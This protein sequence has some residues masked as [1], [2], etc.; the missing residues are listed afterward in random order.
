MSNK[1]FTLEELAEILNVKYTGD[2]SCR[3]SGVSDLKSA[4]KEDV[5]FLS[6]EK[7]T[8]LLKKTSAGIICVNE[9]VD[10]E[11]SKNYLIA[12]D[13]SAIFAKVCEMLI[14]DE[15]RSGFTKIH[16]TACI[17]Q[18]A[19]IGKN[20]EIGPYA[21]I[22]REVVIGDGTIIYSHV[23]V[24]PKSVLGSDCIIY[25]NTVIREQCELGNRVLLQP[26]CVIGSCGY[27]YSSCKKTGVHTKIKQLG[28]V[29]LEDDVEIGSS[30]T[31]DRGRFSHTIIRKGTKI[32]NQCMIGHNCDV[33]MNN[34]IVSMSGLSGSV[35]TGRNVI[36]AAQCGL[37]GHIEIADGVTLAAR[38]T[39]TKS[40]KKPGGIYLGMPAQEIKKELSEIIALK[41]LPKMME[42]FK[43]AEKLLGSF[44]ENA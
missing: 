21:V 17:H 20:V 4:T 28:K 24:G 19:K 22:D 25:A 34:L 43:E 31:V 6:N 35:K 30:T 32:D 10:L 1:S 16:P 40:I 36:I 27:G 14:A 41:K 29:I 5:S 8:S 3:I 15:S 33:G 26:L 7:Y 38:S 23:S 39:P 42:K 18:S 44:K 11:E 12:E 9:G 13:G 37:V 2:K